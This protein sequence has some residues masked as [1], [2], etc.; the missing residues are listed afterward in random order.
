MTMLTRGKGL[1][2]ILVCVSPAAWAQQKQGVSE[3]KTYDLPQSEAGKPGPV[4]GAP[5]S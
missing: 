1:L 4:V 5:G 3:V 2:A